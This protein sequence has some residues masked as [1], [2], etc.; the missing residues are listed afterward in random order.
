MEREKI[1]E[2]L[3]HGKALYDMAEHRLYKP[4]YSHNGEESAIEVYDMPYYGKQMMEELYKEFGKDVLKLE[5]PL[6]A[7]ITNNRYRWINDT[8]VPK[9]HREFIESN[10]SH[11]SLV[12]TLAKSYGS[13]DKGQIEGFLN[14]VVSE[15]TFISTFYESVKELRNELEQF[16][17]SPELAALV[18][19]G[20]WDIDNEKFK[21]Y[22]DLKEPYSIGQICS[23]RYGNEEF[24]VGAYV[25]GEDFTIDYDRYVPC[26]DIE[27]VESK[28]LI[29][30]YIEKIPYGSTPF[31]KVESGWTPDFTIAK[32]SIDSFKKSI[33]KLLLRNKHIEMDPEKYQRINDEGT[34]FLSQVK[35]KFKE[36]ASIAAKK[37][38]LSPKEIT[39]I[40]GIYM[41]FDLS[42]MPGSIENICNKM[43]EAGFN[44]SR[45]M[46]F[47]ENMATKLKL[48][49]TSEK[50]FKKMLTQI[51]NKGK[52]AKQ[53]VGRKEPSPMTK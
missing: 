20:E 7:Y 29:T 19:A 31:E 15:Q 45:K 13:E 18:E 10:E 1:N 37:D 47:F 24:N 17:K 32:D 23:V 12:D 52:E 46:I 40:S 4:W 50:E 3:L 51:I 38:K 33:V 6:S 22:Q 48:S 49:P 16:D 35:K 8:D 5:D 36:F 25:R 30:D 21:E 44:N 27:A 41:S 34:Y 39:I 28:N 26:L 14:R 53:E 11:E 9:L 43:E 42:D 2:N